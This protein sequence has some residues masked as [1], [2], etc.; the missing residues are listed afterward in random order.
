MELNDLFPVAQ[1]LAINLPDGE[2]TGIKFKLVGQDSKQFRDLAR[3]FQQKFLGDAKPTA[4]DLEQMNVALTAACIVGW[5]GLTDSGE[6]VPY[7]KDKALELMAMPELAFIREQVERFT[8]S[9]R[10]FFR[11]GVEAA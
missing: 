11:R 9:R 1:D 8:A 3:Q 6:P 2:P 5:T 10:N 4:D 7:A